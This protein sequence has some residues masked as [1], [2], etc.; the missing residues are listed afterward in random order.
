[1]HELASDRVYLELEAGRYP[2]NID[3]SPGIHRAHTIPQIYN[4]RLEQLLGNQYVV[5]THATVSFYQAL[6]TL[7]YLSRLSYNKMNERVS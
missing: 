3:I 2:Q 6:I 7:C 4:K 1:M 5:V